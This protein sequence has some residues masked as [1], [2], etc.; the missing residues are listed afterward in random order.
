MLTENIR[1]AERA[2]RARENIWAL[3]L[4]FLYPLSY[5][6]KGGPLLNRGGRGLGVGF[7]FL[8][9]PSLPL[10]LVKNRPLVNG[11]PSFL[12]VCLGLLPVF[13][14]QYGFPWCGTSHQRRRTIDLGGAFLR[15]LSLSLKE[16]HFSV[17][18]IFTLHII[19][20]CS[21]IQTGSKQNPSFPLF[22]KKAEL[23]VL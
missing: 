9:T 16:N 1:R 11:L 13:P 15:S 18:D 4:A 14:S 12:V 17:F 6:K 7:R 3:S 20:T 5:R 19:Q 23:K 10:S 8:G 21:T 2:K 22:N